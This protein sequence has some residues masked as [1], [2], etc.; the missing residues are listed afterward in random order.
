MSRPDLSGRKRCRYAKSCEE[1]AYCSDLDFLG[2]LRRAATGL[3]AW[4]DRRFGSIWH[5]FMTIPILPPLWWVWSV[6]T[7][8]TC[9]PWCDEAGL[10]SN[11]DFITCSWVWSWRPVWID[12]RPWLFDALFRSIKDD[13]VEA[14]W[15]ICAAKL[16]RPWPWPVWIPDSTDWRHDL[17]SDGRLLLTVVIRGSSEWSIPW[18]GGSP[19]TLWGLKVS[20][21]H[22]LQ[23]AWPGLLVYQLS[24][25]P[26]TTLLTA[27]S[28]TKSMWV[29]SATYPTLF[30]SD[31][32][33]LKVSGTTQAFLCGFRTITLA[34]D[35]LC[36][37]IK[38]LLQTTSCLPS[39][40]T[41]RCFVSAR[42]ESLQAKPT[43]CERSPRPRCPSPSTWPSFGGGSTSCWRGTHW[44]RLECI[45]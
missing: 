28:S 40:R 15:G 34:R 45:P 24:T 17:T 12:F 5:D 19:R 37:T 30:I 26:T 36:E 44:I 1:S 33:G 41:W 20:V 43:D 9:R 16:S 21:L 42:K 7:F 22:G 35:W 38:L 18:G 25:P 3:S 13:F 31:F 39:P 11:S 2:L 6:W 27:S 8:C 32:A 10:L 4:S 23:T 14:T 29:V